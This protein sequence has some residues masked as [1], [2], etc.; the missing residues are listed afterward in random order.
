VQPLDLAERFLVKFV[1][2][3]TPPDVAALRVYAYEVAD[4]GPPILLQEAK[5]RAPFVTGAS[6]GRTDVTGQQLLYARSLGREL[7]YSCAWV[8]S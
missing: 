1:Y 2:V 6:A 5:Y 8:Q 4:E 3:A 7:A